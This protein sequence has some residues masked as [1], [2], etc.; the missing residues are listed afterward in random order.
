[1]GKTKKRAAK[2]AAALVATGAGVGTQKAAATPPQAKCAHVLA[3][4]DAGLCKEACAALEAHLTACARKPAA[5][6]LPS[7]GLCNNVLG[8]ARRDRRPKAALRIL[9]CMEACKLPVGPVSLRCALFACCDK[10]MVAEA[11]QLMARRDAATGRRLLGKVRA[12]LASA[13]TRSNP[14]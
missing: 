14:S 11:L 2:R 4:V 6:P 12:R 10:G 1:M 13:A 5:V 9:L 3:A 7:V 8:H